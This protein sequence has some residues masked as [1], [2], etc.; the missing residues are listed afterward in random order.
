MKIT[1]AQINFVVGDIDGNKE[2]II[3]AAQ[4]SKGSSLIVFPELS[5]SGFFPHN[6]LSYND[7]IERCE[8]AAHRGQASSS[9]FF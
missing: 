9:A 2:K 7:F 8:K 3:E 5:L 6:L 4:Q 1:L